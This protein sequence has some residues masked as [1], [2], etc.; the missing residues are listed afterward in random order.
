MA[1][2]LLQCALFQFDNAIATWS[3]RR[4]ILSGGLGAKPNDGAALIV[5]AAVDEPH[6]R[7]QIGGQARKVFLLPV[8]E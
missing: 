2:G 1:G 3:S 5:F 4:V 8:A 7:G 6:Q